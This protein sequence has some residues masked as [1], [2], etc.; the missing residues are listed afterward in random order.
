MDRKTWEL[1]HNKLGRNLASR[2]HQEDAMQFAYDVLEVPCSDDC[3]DHI[4]WIHV[5]CDVNQFI[6]NVK[7]VLGAQTL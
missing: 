4:V 7:Q 3:D 6:K 1:L 5:K 2:V